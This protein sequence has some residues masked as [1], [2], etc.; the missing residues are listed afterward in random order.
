VA[1][2]LISVKDLDNKK[3]T[4]P[5]DRIFY[6]AYKTNDGYLKFSNRLEKYKFPTI[7]SIT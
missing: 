3:E 2:W 6:G 7:E 4:Q 1:L 5:S